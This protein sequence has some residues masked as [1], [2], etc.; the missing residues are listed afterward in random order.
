LNTIDKIEVAIKKVDVQHKRLKKER[1]TGEVVFTIKLTYN[2][3]GVR[4]EE[5]TLNQKV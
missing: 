4:T 2:Q 3:G 1:F 5:V